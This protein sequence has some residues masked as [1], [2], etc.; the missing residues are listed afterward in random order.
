MFVRGAGDLADHARLRPRELRA[1]VG[2]RDG[3]ERVEA[4]REPGRTFE[5]ARRHSEALARI[6]AQT[7]EPDATVR[8]AAD[9]RPGSLA[10][11]APHG[12][13]APASQPEL[14]VDPRRE[15]RA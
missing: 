14:Q 15:A 4:R 5:R 8:P 13:F 6:V 7:D 11:L 2:T 3:R 1:I 10:E 9:E 12:R